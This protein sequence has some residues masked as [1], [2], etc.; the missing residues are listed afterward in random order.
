METKESLFTIKRKEFVFY[1]L[2]LFLTSVFS[3]TLL[4][5]LFIYISYKKYAESMVIDGKIVVFKGKLYEI[6]WRYLLWLILTS[7]IV[8]IYQIA[9]SRI[10]S[11]VPS[12]LFRF[13]SSTLL[14]FL[15]SFFLNMTTRK[16]KYRS[17]YFLNEQGKSSYK[18]NLFHLV[19]Y[20]AIIQV[21][22]IISLGLF[23]WPIQALRFK[24]EYEH[25][26]ISSYTFEIHFQVKESLV[27]WLKNLFF[28]FITFGFYAIIMK[29]ES[30]KHNIENLHIKSQA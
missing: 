18:G 19:F 13:L 24:Y 9:L 20:Q 27:R 14:T 17:M 1:E 11:F 8:T 23:Y 2:L 21:L 10:S 29:Y 7:L 3:L 15:S 12:F 28:L 30:M 4:T 25:V 6:Y 5:P 16:W 26:M 22:N